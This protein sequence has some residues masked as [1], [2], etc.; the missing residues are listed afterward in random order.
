MAIRRPRSV[1]GAEID[2]DTLRS[3]AGAL[4]VALFAL[5]ALDLVV[6][7][8]AIGSLGAFEANPLFAPFVGGGM[9][10]AL[11]LGIPVYILW[12]SS[13]VTMP[14]AVVALRVVVA[15]YVVVVLI[16]LVQVATITSRI[17]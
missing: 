14:H 15:I 1:R 7:R 2:I 9:G 4:A 11:K 10:V 17:L 13:R 6:T 12:V 3:D 16:G 5:S 8:F